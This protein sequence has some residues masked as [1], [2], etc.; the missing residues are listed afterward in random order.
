MRRLRGKE[1][2]HVRDGRG[3]SEGSSQHQ[4]SVEEGFTAAFLKVES[5]EH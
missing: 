1:M 4:V 2:V 5:S 3:L